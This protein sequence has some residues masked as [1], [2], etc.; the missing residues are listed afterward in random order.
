M[1]SV[2][3]YCQLGN[4]AARSH[5]AEQA[6]SHIISFHIVQ[7][8]LQFSKHYETVVDLDELW[9]EAMVNHLTD[10]STIVAI[11]EIGFETAIRPA[12]QARSAV[13]GGN[14]V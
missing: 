2:M 9:R 8:L 14:W 7:H 5:S 1:A 10:G 6:P 13:R 3:S 4:Y 12:H 11:R